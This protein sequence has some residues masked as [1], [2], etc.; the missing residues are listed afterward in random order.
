V[1]AEND[2]EAHLVASPAAAGGKIL[3]RS[4]TQV[5]AIGPRR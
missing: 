4:D 3:L 1:L 2:L 5:F